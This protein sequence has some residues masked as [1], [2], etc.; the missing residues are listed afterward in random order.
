MKT[1]IY[2]GTYTDKESEGIYRFVFD[3]GRFSDPI[4]F[5]KIEDPKYLCAYEDKIVSVNNKD[6]RGAVSLIDTEGNI[7]DQRI[8]EEVCSCYVTAKDNK[9]YT[10]NYHE[11]SF[12]QITIKEDHFTEVKTVRV[13]DRG[14]CHQVLFHEGKILVPSLFLDKVL[15]YDEDLVYIDEIRF[16]EGSGPR[17][18]VFDKEGKNLYLVSELSNELFV[19][20][21]KTCQII[22]QIT[23]LPDGKRDLKGSAAIRMSKDE[24]HLYVSTRGIDLLS[25]IEIKE[26]SVSLKQCVSCEGK[27]PRDFIISDGYLL[28]A[29]RFTDEVISF[30]I[31][32]DGTIGEKTDTIKI[33]DAVS[34][35]AR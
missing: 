4:L 23:V 7:I 34:L 31:K 25:V 22:D 5:C 14:G 12:S 29:N 19:I 2:A 20:D 3:E 26:R 21:M 32:E 11:G 1:M 18:G 24:R 35:I 33:P 28:C 9:I 10:A 6:G 17:H 13:K 15:I 16:P 27:H 30:R 8:Y